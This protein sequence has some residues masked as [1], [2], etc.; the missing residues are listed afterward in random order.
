MLD[1]GVT[2]LLGAKRASHGFGWAR[3]VFQTFFIYGNKIFLFL[4]L[5]M[6]IKCTLLTAGVCRGAAEPGFTAALL[7]TRMFYSP[8]ISHLQQG[9]LGWELVARK[10]C[11]KAEDDMQCG[12]GDAELSVW[13]S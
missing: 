13:C 3:A 1:C 12:V 5:F 11:R 7:G 10:K 6:V 4:V 8:S 2:F 9:V